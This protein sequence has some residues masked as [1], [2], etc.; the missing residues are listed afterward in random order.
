[1]ASSFKVKVDYTRH[2]LNFRFDAGT[3][4]GVLKTKDTYLVRVYADRFPSAFGYGEASPLPRLSIDDVPDFE[5]KLEEICL[6]L[7]EISLPQSEHGILELVSQQVPEKFPSIRFA[8]EVALLDLLHGGNKRILKNGFYDHHTPLT[9]NGL[10]WMGE[11]DFMLEQIRLKLEEGY[12]CIK[13]KIGSI[14]FDQECAL[15]SY[16]RERYS[17][18]QITLRVDA[19]GAFLPGEALS[20]LQRLAEF[21]IHSIE[22]PIR[23]GQWE[24]M[25]G[26]CRTSPIPIALDEELIGLN[27]I[28]E[29]SRLLEEIKPQNII[30]KP[31]LI[32]GIRA[33]REWISL[34]EEMQIGWWMTSA[35][36][37]NIGLNAIAQLASA[38]DPIIPQG[39][40][41][42]QLYHNNIDSPLTIDK[43]RIFYQRSGAWGGLERLFGK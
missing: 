20:K 14:D 13:M 37:S 7:P 35:L 6:K 33:T 10:I 25:K 15:L 2:R 3:S 38:Y 34:A 40:G 19:N 26:L 16:I 30:L 17:S 43:G 27:D 9:I 24:A 12:N 29:K 32:G 41:T 5:E 36:E 31:T 11:P 28:K 4:R 18:D 42:G 21:A 23:P 39:L 22:Q 8:L 1:M